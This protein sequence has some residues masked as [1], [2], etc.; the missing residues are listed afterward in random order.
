MRTDKFFIVSR[1]GKA[2]GAKTANE[3]EYKA[4]LDMIIGDLLR[5]IYWPEWPGAALLL[6]VASKLLVS[7]ILD[8]SLERVS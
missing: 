6:V 7:L 5:V 2:K 3:S 8:A 4:I 1:A